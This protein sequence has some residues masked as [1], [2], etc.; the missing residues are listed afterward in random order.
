M[1]D[2]PG[3][4][5]QSL[6]LQIVQNGFSGRIAVQSLISVA[7]FVDPAFLIHHDDLLET[8]AQ[9]DLVVI[10]IV[11]RRDLDAA[12][13]KVHVHIG[14]RDDRNLPVRQRQPDRLSDQVTEPFIFR[15][16]RHGRIPQH[17]LRTRGGNFQIAGAIGEWVLDVPE[18]AVS[19]L[20]LHFCI[21][22]RGQ[23]LGAPVGYPLAAVD[24]SLVVQLDKGVP[25]GPGQIFIHGKGFSGIIHRAAQPVQLTL[26]LFA[27]FFRP[28]PG[29]LQELL[30]A[31]F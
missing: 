25:H 8:M 22:N 3:F 27:V 10:G 16:N 14:I 2:V 1:H 28:V 13:T 30:P 11:G 31:D 26:N 23:A 4:E 12:R 21:G 29:V 7:L 5:Q 19:F 24:Q 20:I 6:R 17:R 9:P 18:M 15:M